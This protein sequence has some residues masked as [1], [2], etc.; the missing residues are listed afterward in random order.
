MTVARRFP[1]H[2]LKKG[3]DSARLER[4]PSA[5]HLLHH[6]GLSPVG[7]FVTTIG[8]SSPPLAGMAEISAAVLGATRWMMS[9]PPSGVAALG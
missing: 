6:Q 8:V 9:V 3:Q 2:F 5:R 4:A 1:Y 7:A